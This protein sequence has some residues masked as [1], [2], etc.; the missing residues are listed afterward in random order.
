MVANEQEMEKAL[1]YDEKCMR[2]L[3]LEKKNEKRKYF[4][5]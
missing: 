3:K 4:R 2:P 5:D 1:R